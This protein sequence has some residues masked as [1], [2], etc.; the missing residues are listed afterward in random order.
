M[1]QLQLKPVISNVLEAAKLA[2]VSAMNDQF[3][4]SYA[5][6]AHHIYA[7]IPEMLIAEPRTTTIEGAD[8][9]KKAVSYME[10]YIADITNPDAPEFRKISCGQLYNNFK[11]IATGKREFK[12]FNLREV[13]EGELLTPSLV[14]LGRALSQRDL[15][16][17]YKETVPCEMPVTNELKDI[18][19]FEGTL[20]TQDIIRNKFNE[21]I[22][23]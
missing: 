5:L 19:F 4:P 20:E 21:W 3:V 22:K 6:E 14:L 12:I 9:I 11:V 1:K 8:G 2:S 13:G 16:I 7:L 23:K 18:H 17:T 10:S 15:K